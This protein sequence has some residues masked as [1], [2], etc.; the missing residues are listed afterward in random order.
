MESSENPKV[1]IRDRERS[2]AKILKAVGEIIEQEGIDKA[3]PKHIAQR[4]RV[5][6][7]LIYHYFENVEN[8]VKQYCLSQQ[9]RHEI[10]NAIR[11]ARASAQNTQDHDLAQ[12]MLA[13]LDDLRRDQATCDILKLEFRIRQN[14]LSEAHDQ[15]I[16]RLLM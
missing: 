5:N 7:V 1:K 13:F 10:S 4:A 8:L 2:K 16:L 11:N 12:M 14:I 9:H 15:A 3:T 6:K